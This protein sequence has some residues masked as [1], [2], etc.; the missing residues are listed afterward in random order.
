MSSAPLLDERLALA[1]AA[2]TVSVIVD[3][4]QLEF[5]DSSGLRVLLSRVAGNSNGTRYLLTQG[6]PQVR[7]LF[8]VAGV[9]DRLPF[10][11]D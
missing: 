1:E 5:I 10:E 7:R 6:S 9:I 8:E 11:S 2:D 3:I 4:D